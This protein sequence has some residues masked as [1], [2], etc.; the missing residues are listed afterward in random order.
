MNYISHVTK[1][2]K[3]CSFDLPHNKFEERSRKI[4]SLV[5]INQ[6]AWGK[7]VLINYQF[8]QKL[9]I[10]GNGEFNH[11]AIILTPLPPHMWA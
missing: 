9:K 6:N 4:L 7:S 3:G 10:L 11:L 2:T 1:C 5:K 8:S